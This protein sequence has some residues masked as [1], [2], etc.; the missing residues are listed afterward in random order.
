MQVHDR[1]TRAACYCSRVSNTN[2]TMWWVLSPTVR[3]GFVIKVGFFFAPFVLSEKR[4]L[5]ANT[6]QN[7]SS[8]RVASVRLRLWEI[9]HIETEINIFFFSPHFHLSP[10]PLFLN[11]RTPQPDLLESLRSDTQHTE[12]A[13]RIPPP[14]HPPPPPPPTSLFDEY[15]SCR[16]RRCRGAAA[17]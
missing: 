12:H 1:A 14:T 3:N 4:R 2:Q 6:T 16:K 10:A 8:I 17:V 5:G 9:P 7:L 15:V 13:D 11:T